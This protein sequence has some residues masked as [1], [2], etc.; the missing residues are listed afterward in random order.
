MVE[1]T[2]EITKRKNAEESLSRLTHEVQN[3][4]STH[5]TL[6]AGDEVHNI[7]KLLLSANAFVSVLENG[8][9]TEAKNIF[10]RD[11]FLYN[12][13]AS[14]INFN[15]PDP[16]DGEINAVVNKT[17]GGF[18]IRKIMVNHNYPSLHKQATEYLVLDFDSTGTLLDFNLCITEELYEKFVAQ[19]EYGNDWGNRQEIIKFI[20][21]YRTAFLTRDME[22]INLM[23][24]E[25]ALILIGRK[26]KPRTSP[27][28]EISYK[29]LPG[30]P[31]FEQIQLTKKQYLERQERIF[32]KQK[33]I[34]IDFSTFDI[35]K[36][37]NAEGVYGVEMRQ[38]YSSTT[39]ADEGYLFLLIDFNGTDP[40]IY[41][42]AWQ[43]NE[44][45]S[46]ALVNTSNFRVYK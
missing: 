2:L 3:S 14:Y 33:D 5:L 19:A 8:Q 29:Q 25:E 44:W 31:G 7:D 36:K 40:L 18:E 27:A 22:T 39:Y 21:K 46:A 24:A 15:Q 20:E 28:S 4:F 41:I 32:S 34:F 30:Q 26:I 12:K 13:I 1:T 10:G 6:E 9:E 37:N 11:A 17:S 38:N 43:P 16:A 35:L 45:D 42:R 23:F